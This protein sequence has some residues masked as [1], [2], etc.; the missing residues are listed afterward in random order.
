MKKAWLFLLLLLFCPPLQSEETPWNTLEATAKQH[1]INL[2]D[3][4]TS[5]PEPDEL[6]AARYIYKELNKHGI[7]WDIFIP[8]PGRANLLARIK[9]TEPAPEGPIR[10]S[11]RQ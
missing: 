2:I 3:I 4:D 11:K 6:S 5:K 9:G 1:L 10:P 8:S 7:D